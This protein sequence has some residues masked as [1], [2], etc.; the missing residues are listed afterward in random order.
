IDIPVMFDIWLGLFGSVYARQATGSGHGPVFARHGKACAAMYEQFYRLRAKPFSLTPDP[1]FIFWADPHSLA[2]SML[3]YGIVNRAG[4]TVITGEVG[5]GKTTLIRYL[6]S[7]VTD[8]LNIGVVSNMQ[9][10]RGD[11]LEW[12]LM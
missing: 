5:A 3:E 1:S 4:F 12:V 7:R 9:K 2:F 8:E 10:G 11:L 6:L